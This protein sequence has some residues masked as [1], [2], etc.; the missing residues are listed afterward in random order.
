LL[1]RR[2]APSLI[3]DS[4]TWPLAS[5]M[6]SGH[7]PGASLISFAVNETGKRLGLFEGV[8]KA[9]RANEAA[10]DAE[11]QLERLRIVKEWVEFVDAMPCRQPR[12]IEESKYDVVFETTWAVHHVRNECSIKRHSKDPKLLRLLEIQ[13]EVVTRLL[14]RTLLDYSHWS[15]ES[16]LEWPAWLQKASHARRSVERTGPY[17]ATPIANWSELESD[18]DME[19]Y[20][21]DRYGN[22]DYEETFVPEPIGSLACE[23][24]QKFLKA[25]S[26]YYQSASIKVKGAFAH[27]S[28]CVWES[29]TTAPVKGFCIR[30]CVQVPKPMVRRMLPQRL[31]KELASAAFESSGSWLERAQGGLRSDVIVA[32]KSA[33]RGFWPSLQPAICDF[34]PKP[35]DVVRCLRHLE[36]HWCKQAVAYDRQARELLPNVRAR[37]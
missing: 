15:E 36:D 12:F 31:Q 25:L 4:G 28:S 24:R 11:R 2:L 7:D 37:D 13:K 1:K 26:M 6:A 29:Y 35:G 21:P 10:L 30:L 22:D 3:C 23:E 5:T 8:A 16:W 34:V 20:D 14:G 27:G 17:A 33:K 18:D 19:Y 32:L 9:S